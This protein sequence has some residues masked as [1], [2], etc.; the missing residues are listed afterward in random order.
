MYAYVC[1]YILLACTVVQLMERRSSP[2]RSVSLSLSQA[3]LV[4]TFLV[5]SSV[6]AFGIEPI[7]TVARVDTS[8]GKMCYGVF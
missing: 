6:S 3:F 2:P 5:H 7:K 8:L 4:D 1:M